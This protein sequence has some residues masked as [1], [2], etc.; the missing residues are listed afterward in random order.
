MYGVRMNLAATVAIKYAAR[1]TTRRR[2][3]G[4]VSIYN[5]FRRKINSFHI[6]T[7]QEQ[8][9]T[10]TGLVLKENKNNLFNATK[11]NEQLMFH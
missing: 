6:E 2:F 11:V 10:K 4:L 3:M 5:S 8:T 9:P 7:R 1:L